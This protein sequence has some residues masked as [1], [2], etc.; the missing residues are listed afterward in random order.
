MKISIRKYFHFEFLCSSSIGNRDVPFS[1][2]HS[3]G[4]ILYNK[5][6][7]CD[8]VSNELGKEND[9]E[10][11][12]KDPTYRAEQEFVPGLETND[13]HTCRGSCGKY[14]FGSFIFQWILI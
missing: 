9:E 1:M 12:S 6:V 2:F 4:K 7:Y 3:L 13:I 11:K 10:K 5:R 14:E 8:Y